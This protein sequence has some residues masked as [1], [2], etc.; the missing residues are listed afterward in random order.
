MLVDFTIGAGGRIIAL[1]ATFYDLTCRMTIR[2]ACNWSRQSVEK[3]R[4]HLMHQIQG[5]T[6]IKKNKL[7]IGLATQQRYVPLSRS[8]RVEGPNKLRGPSTHGCR[9]TLHVGFPGGSPV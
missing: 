4:R 3:L 7:V 5:Q 2:M 8:E 1:R 6:L 9:Y